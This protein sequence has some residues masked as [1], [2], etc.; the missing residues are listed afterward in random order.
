VW[1]EATGNESVGLWSAGRIGSNYQA[2]WQ[3][4]GRRLVI[5]LPV[6]F[7]VFGRCDPWLTRTFITVVGTMGIPATSRGEARMRGQMQNC[8][9]AACRTSGQCRAPSRWLGRGYGRR[10]A[11]GMMGRGQ[12]WNAS[13]VCTMVY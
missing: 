9:Q 10:Q 12:R 3:R 4:A 2:P 8:P 11:M 7:A 13:V 5:G 1:C 6:T